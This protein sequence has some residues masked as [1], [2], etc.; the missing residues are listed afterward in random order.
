MAHRNTPTIIYWH[1]DNEYL[2]NT[3]N[4]HQ[5]ALRPEQG[6]H[7]LTLVDEQGESLVQQ[8]EIMAK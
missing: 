1:L 3:T 5:M 6:R 8:F 7:T 2:G 4:F